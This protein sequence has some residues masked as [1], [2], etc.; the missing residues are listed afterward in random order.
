[1]LTVA[2]CAEIYAMFTY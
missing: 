1:V 2:V